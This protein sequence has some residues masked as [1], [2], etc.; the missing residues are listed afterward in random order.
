M[1]SF[2]TPGATLTLDFAYRGARTDALLDDLDRITIDAGGRVNPYK[3][4]R[5]SPATFEASFPM[6]RDF[7]RHIDP[8]FTSNFWR[9]VTG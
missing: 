5:M 2:P 9:R 4:A 1:M 6:W 3:D 8:A 7:A